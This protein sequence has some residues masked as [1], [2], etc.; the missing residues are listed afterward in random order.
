VAQASACAVLIFLDA[1]G[2]Q[3]EARATKFRRRTLSLA[4]A[5]E[6][7]HGALHFFPGGV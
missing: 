7:G 4:E 2:A 5:L 6:F 3:A 1:K